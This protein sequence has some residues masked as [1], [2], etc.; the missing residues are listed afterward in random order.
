MGKRQTY[1]AN[2]AHIL[3]EGMAN[4]LVKDQ[5]LFGIHADALERLDRHRRDVEVSITSP[6]GETRTETRR[7]FEGDVIDVFAKADLERFKAA[8]DEVTQKG[9]RGA[10]TQYMGPLR[11]KIEA[12][13]AWHEKQA[14][15]SN[16]KPK[17]KAK[18]KAKGKRRR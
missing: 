13:L 18:K 11:V 16:D 15:K 2:E 17:R 8:L 1:T 3:S 14:A 9:V 5:G 7:L 10:I 4:V 12:G 6:N